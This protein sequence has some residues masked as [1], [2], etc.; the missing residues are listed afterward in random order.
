MQTNR[1]VDPEAWEAARRDLMTREKAHQKDRDDLAAA[2]RALP[3]MR[4]DKPYVFQT[5]DG[6]AELAAL[7]GD[8]EQ[9][10]VWH[11]MFGRDWEEGCTS[12]SFWADHYDRAVVHLAHRDVSLVAV[13]TAPLDR[14]EAYRRRMGWSFRWVSSGDNGFNRDFAVTFT[15]EEVEVGAPIYNLGTLPPFAQELPGLS[16]FA[17]GD[18]GAVYRTYSTYARGLDPLNAT[19][20]H[21]DLVPKGRDEAGLS[22]SM[23]WLRRHDR[24]EAA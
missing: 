22:H 14:L 20:Q 18:D 4:I 15:P 11:F 24:Y 17:R 3:W 10:I 13:S 16:V 23:A 1:I 7:F 2:R 6:P 9:L 19:Y 8:R 5:P 21:L 12:C